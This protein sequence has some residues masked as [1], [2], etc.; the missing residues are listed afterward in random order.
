MNTHTKK[1]LCWCLLWFVLFFVLTLTLCTLDVQP[2]GP[3]ESM[4]G[5]AGLNTSFHTLTGQSALLD[6]LTDISLYIAFLEVA[7]FAVLGLIQLVKQK[8]FL[9]VDRQLYALAI[10]YIVMACFY[11]C[12][13][14]IVINMRPVLVDGLL[15]PSYPSSHTMMCVTIYSTGIVAVYSL[16]SKHTTF[17][18]WFTVI[19]IALLTFGVVGRLLCGMHWFTDIAGGL[20]IGA[21]LIALYKLLIDVFQ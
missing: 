10:V 16:F 4:I 2:L 8:S 9:K 5:W 19:S 21:A 11:I 15:E 20:L 12:F 6:K 14:H 18:H 13:E 7:G 17:D 3:L 1:D